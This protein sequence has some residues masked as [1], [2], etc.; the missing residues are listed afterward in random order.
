MRRTRR[1]TLDLLR[2]AYADAA[3]HAERGDVVMEEQAIETAETLDTYAPPGRLTGPDGR[4]RRRADALS[5]WFRAVRASA[6][7]GD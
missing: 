6:A 3:R 2:G 7:M 5:A 1:E 4:V